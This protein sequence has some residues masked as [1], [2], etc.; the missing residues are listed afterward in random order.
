MSKISKFLDIQCNYNRI[1]LGIRPIYV[2]N[3]VHLYIL[4]ERCP[5]IYKKIKAIKLICSFNGNGIDLEV[6]F[7]H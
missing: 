5:T 4:S 1:K 3:D 6:V 7:F 2:I